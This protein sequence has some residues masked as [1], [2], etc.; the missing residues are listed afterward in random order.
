MGYL[1]VS[2]RGRLQLLRAPPKAAEKVKSP[3]LPM[4]NCRGAGEYFQKQR[5]RE[6]RISPGAG[7]QEPAGQIRNRAI[8]I[9]SLPRK[10]EGCSRGAVRGNRSF[11]PQTFYPKERMESGTQLVFPRVL[12]TFGCKPS[13]RGSGRGSPPVQR[14]TRAAQNA[15][16]QAAQRGFRNKRGF[17]PVKQTTRFPPIQAHRRT[18]AFPPTMIPNRSTE[19]RLSRLVPCLVSRFCV[20]GLFRAFQWKCCTTE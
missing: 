8:P 6:R 11:T 2:G 13:A 9:G 20:Q 7:G 19:S 15:G 14:R 5:D 1:I 10:K 16:A 3:F 18:V 17:C 12:T 4:L